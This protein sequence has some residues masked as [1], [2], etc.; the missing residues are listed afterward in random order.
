MALYK[1]KRH[2]D[3]SDARAFD[4]LEAPD[5]VAPNSGIYR[6][7]MCGAEVACKKSHRLPPGNHHVHAE[8]LSGPIQWR[9]IVLAET[10]GGLG[11]TAQTISAP[12]RAP[13]REL[14]ID[15]DDDDGGGGD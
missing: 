2:L 4:L 7:E 8:D 11:I 14:A 5:S 3:E 6:C 13:G 1:H 9:L 15:Q 10:Y 12:L